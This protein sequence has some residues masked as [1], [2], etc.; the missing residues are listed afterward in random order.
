MTVLE[1]CSNGLLCIPKEQDMDS[2]WK[3]LYSSIFFITKYCYYICFYSLSNFYQ[4]YYIQITLFLGIL[5]IVLAFSAVARLVLL[6]GVTWHEQ[7]Y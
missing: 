5:R 7:Y 2:F 3:Y 1:K 4:N 6:V